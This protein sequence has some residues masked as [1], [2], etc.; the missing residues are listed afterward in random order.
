MAIYLDHAATTSLLPEVLEGYIVALQSVGNASS[1]HSHG[2]AAKRMLEEARERVAA[3]LGCDPVEVIF[4]SGGTEAVNTAVK[5]VFWA[6]RAAGARIL[7]PG[8]EHHATADAAAWLA[9]SQGARVEEL[10]VDAEGRLAPAVLE[11]ALAEGGTA[12]VSAVWANSEVGTVQKVAE[13]AAVALRA[14]VPIHADAVAAFGQ[15]PVDFRASG[16]SALSVA[17]HKVGAPVG[18]GA[19]VLARGTAAEPLVHGGGQQRG[20]RSGTQDVAGAV[21]FGIAATL[22]AERLDAHASAL[23]AL[24]DRL[25]AGVLATVPGARLRGPAPGPDR[26]PGNAHFTFDGCDGDSLLL[27]LDFAGIS[28]ST[29]AACQAGVPEVSTVLLAMGVPEV[30]ARGALRFSLGAGT[31]ADDVDA[32]LRVLPGVVERAQRAGHSDRVPAL[33]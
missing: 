3:A 1:I 28:V 8:G 30:E 6:R 18:T 9:A 4:T 17:G 26:L 15:V 19:L 10:P 31:T 22:A 16:L 29:G 25:I 27:L 21:A 32:L 7:L 14:G 33:G 23:V 5:G 13:L 12:L 11:A 2:Q 24:R 20:I